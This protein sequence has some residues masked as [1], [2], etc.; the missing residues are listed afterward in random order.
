MTFQNG[1]WM[2][3]SLSPHDPVEVNGTPISSSSGPYLL[4][5]G[6]QV[7]IGEAVFRFHLP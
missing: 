4:A 1:R 2:I 3:E 5:P 7:R 6:D